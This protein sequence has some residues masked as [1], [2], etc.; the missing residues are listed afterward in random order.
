MTGSV[1]TAMGDRI[2]V[3]FLVCRVTTQ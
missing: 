3:Q 2:R 1:S